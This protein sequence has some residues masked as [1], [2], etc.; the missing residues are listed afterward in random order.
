METSALI[1]MVLANCTIAG[2]TFYFF[3]KM[4]KTPIKTPEEEDL[5]Y[6]RGG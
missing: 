5:N 3:N 4:L 2:F 1:M 6:P